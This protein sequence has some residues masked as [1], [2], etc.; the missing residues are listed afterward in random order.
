MPSLKRLKQHK[1]LLDTHVWIWMV[2]GDPKIK[3]S[4]RKAIETAK[5]VFLS[6]ISV[7]EIG[8][9]V[10]SG[11]VELELDRLDWVEQSIEIAGFE[12]APISPKI[13]IQSTRLPGTIHGD[14]A[15]RL[16]IAAA[17]ELNAVLVT[18]DRKI[19]EYGRG[20]Y[21]HVFDPTSSNY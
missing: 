10:Q 19:L 2:E 14:P 15:D 4:A 8:M 16:L 11:R 1:I 13:A 5:T 17:H 18:C 9:L 21:I 6:P 12:V 7:W 3:A 20:N